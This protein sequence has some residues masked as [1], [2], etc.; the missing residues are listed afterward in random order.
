MVIYTS[1]FCFKSQI[2]VKI[3]R[4]IWSPAKNPKTN[5]NTCTITKLSSMSS[6]YIVYFAKEQKSHFILLFIRGMK[7]I[8][9][10]RYYLPCIHIL[11]VDRFHNSHV[12]H[13]TRAYWFRLI[14]IYSR[15]RCGLQLAFGIIYNSVQNYKPYLSFLPLKECLHELHSEN[16]PLSPV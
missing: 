1:T 12:D 5:C 14:N 6:H 8:N 2:S 4:I 15:K 13:I 16:F 10:F 11:D 9:D 3:S 7:F